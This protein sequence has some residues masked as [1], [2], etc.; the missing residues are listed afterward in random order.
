M[1]AAAPTAAII[2]EAGPVRVCHS[3]S[4]VAAIPGAAAPIVRRRR[5]RSPRRRQIIRPQPIAPVTGKA[6]I[7]VAMRQPWR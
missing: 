1:I 3:S 7:S 2:C 4:S 6:A 5:P